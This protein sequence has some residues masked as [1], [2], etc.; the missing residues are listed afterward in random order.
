MVRSHIVDY[1]DNQRYWSY[2]DIADTAPNP[3][4]I[5]GVSSL[6]RA[7]RIKLVVCSITS[8]AR[9]EV[10]VAALEIA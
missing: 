7:S 3:L 1:L 6:K 9:G 4:I 10:S 5:V 8:I 2:P